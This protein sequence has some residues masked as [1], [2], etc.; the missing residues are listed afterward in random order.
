VA[1]FIVEIYVARTDAS[2]VEAGATR[3]RLAAYELSREGTPV[4]YL[5][6]IFVPEDETC[7]YLY[8]AACAK[9]VREAVRRAELPF[10]NVAETLSDR[11]TSS[12]ALPET[13]SRREREATSHDDLN[14]S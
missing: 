4:R 1:E 6:S 7:F 13:G 8:E 12:V 2:A 5:R 14:P 11:A 9:D 3:G 10:V